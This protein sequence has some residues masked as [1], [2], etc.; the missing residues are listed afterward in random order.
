[1]V[2]D[3]LMSIEHWWHDRTWE[4]RSTRTKINPNVTLLT[5]N[6]RLSDLETNSGL[7]GDRQTDRQAGR[8]ATIGP[9]NSVSALS[10]I[11]TAE[12]LSFAPIF[13]I[14]PFQPQDA[15]IQGRKLDPIQRGGEEAS[16]LMVEAQSIQLQTFSLHFE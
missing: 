12:L 9:C 7:R 5:V 2:I 16:R 10:I 15:S 3:G 8:Q 14:A 4:G 11:S 1:M 6:T 13:R